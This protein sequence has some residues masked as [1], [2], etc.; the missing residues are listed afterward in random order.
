MANGCEAVF[1]FEFLN[2][3]VE[4]FFKLHLINRKKL[5]V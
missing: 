1:L 4:R 2:E 5:G 3:L